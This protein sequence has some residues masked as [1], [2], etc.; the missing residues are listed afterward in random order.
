MNTD[1][2][3]IEVYGF[4]TNKEAVNSSRQ[5][6]NSLFPSTTL[7]LEVGNFL[8]F[9]IHNYGLN[10][11]PDLFKPLEPVMFD[12]IIANPP[13]VRTQI[14]G[15][16]Q[17]QSLAKR[18]D[19]TGRIDLYYAF[20]LGMECVLKKEGTAG[21][22]VSNRFMTTKSGKSIRKA[23]RENCNI[24]HVWDLGDTKLFDAAVLPA[25]LLI[26]GKHRQTCEPPNFTSI[27]ETDHEGNICVPHPIAALEKQGV[28]KV[29]DGRNFRVQ[30]GKLSTTDGSPDEVWRITTD[31]V[32]TWL[33]TVKSHT[34]GLFGDIG[35]IRVGVKTCADKVFI[36]KN[37]YDF[38]EQERPELLRPLATH[39]IARQFKADTSKSVYYILYPYEVTQGKRTVVDLNKYPIS[40]TYLEYHR[41]TLEGRKYVIKAG[42]KWYEIWVPQD[43]SAWS[44]PKLVFRD[45]AEEPT[46]WLD[47]DGSVVNGDCYWMICKPSVSPELLWLATAI[48][49]SRFIELFYDHSFHNKLYSGRRRFITQYVEKFP[50]PNPDNSTSRKII[51]KCKEIYN[52]IPSED[53]RSMK[54]ELD[55]LIWNAFGM[56]E[57]SIKD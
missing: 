46:F 19:L 37:W 17:A 14:L 4:D 12:L 22:I 28:I 25:I 20:I 9:V 30:H 54:K 35:E 42:R 52:R 56:T 50:L 51:E 33:S 38:P 29:K 36:R 7:Y 21:I 57:P 13:Y 45:I 24:K 26:E 34:W 31:K 3:H 44:N 43:P 5:R 27:Y 47:Y 2:R 41:S 11:M 32:N 1:D 15:A 49:N 23:I 55:S 6:L 16:Q 8:E 10:G 40:K 39:H 53:T 48:G 18:F